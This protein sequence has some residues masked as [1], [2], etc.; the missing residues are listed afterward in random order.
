MNPTLL[1]PIDALE[2]KNKI[3]NGLQRVGIRYIGDLVRRTET[4]L[5]DVPCFGPIAVRE[6]K[7]VLSE[8]HLSLG[9]KID[10]W[11]PV[12]LSLD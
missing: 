10:N 7:Q 5:L 9:M 1:H 12:G 3:Q 6:I 8:M 11:P 2:L 4:E